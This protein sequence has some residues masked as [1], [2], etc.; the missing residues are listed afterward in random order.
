MNSFS[1][2]FLVAFSFIIVFLT[3]AKA[4]LTYDIVLATSYDDEISFVYN[5]RE[6]GEQ[7]FLYTMDCQSND[8]N[9]RSIRK[10][11]KIDLLGD[12]INLPFSDFRNDTAYSIDHIVKIDEGGYFL[13]GHAWISDTNEGLRNEFDYY[14]RWDNS[15]NIVWE[16]L[17]TRP[18]LFDTLTRTRHFKILKLI[19][20]NF[21]VGRTIAYRDIAISYKY[22][23]TEID[24]NS[25]DLIEYNIQDRSM[26]FLQGL[27]YNHDSSN[28]LVHLSRSWLNDCKRNSPGVYTID[29]STYDTLSSFCYNRD[30]DDPYKYWCVHVPFNAQIRS[31]GGLILSGTGN[32]SNL[33]GDDGDYLFVYEYDTSFNL[34]NRAFYTDPD[35]LYDAGW[36]ESMDFNDA[37]EILIAGNH[38]RHVGPYSS[39]YSYI[40]LAKLDEDMQLIS[41]RY[42]GGDAEYVVHSMDATNDGGM[43]VSGTRYDYLVNDS[44][45]DAFIFKTDANLWVDIQ[46]NSTIEMHKAII[47]P[48]PGENTINLRTTDFPCQF[49]LF[50]ISGQAM[51]SR[52]INDHITQIRTDFIQAGVY[53]WV[54]IKDNYQIDKGKW[55]KQ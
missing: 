6:S 13:A 51:I 34:V 3:Q 54:L 49:R 43:V 40:Y 5:D 53:F 24:I 22:Y 45:H 41:E 36:F 42:I 12:T 26:G 7:I 15:Y 10:I 55:I 11:Y 4:Q 29:T 1:M 27:T 32:C 28:I 20:G 9:C 46:E 48:N 52:E 2:R 33:Y 21:L 17:Q 47:Y 19:N 16:S 14:L 18:T 50:D 37:G 44:E 39:V 23:L 38:N 31:D 25:G 8:T 35:T 30:D